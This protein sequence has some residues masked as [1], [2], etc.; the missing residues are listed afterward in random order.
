MTAAAIE[1]VRAC[2]FWTGLEY[3]NLVPA[4]EED[5]RQFVFGVRSDEELPWIAPELQRRLEGQWNR[6][7]VQVAYCGLFLKPAFAVSLH[8]ALGQPPGVASSLKIKGAAACCLIP[9]DDTG[10][11]CGELFFSSL[12]WFMSKLREHVSAGRSP[13]T[14]SVSGFADDE[15][16]L[17]SAVRALLVQRQLVPPEAT[18]E[19][20]A[21][22]SD[23]GSTSTASPLPAGRPRL[24]GSSSLPVATPT[25]PPGKDKQAS[26]GGAKAARQRISGPADMRPIKLGD[27]TAIL[28][29]MAKQWG[30]APPRIEAGV[31]AIRIKVVSVTEGTKTVELDAMNSL[32]AKDVIRVQQVL[33]GGGQLGDAAKAYLRLAP[34]LKR[35]DLRGEGLSHFVSMLSPAHLPVGAWPDFPLVSAQQFAVN[36]AC[37]HLAGGGLY[38]VNGPPGTGKSTLLRDVIADRLVERAH[39]MAAFDDPETAFI[40]SR[41]IEGR[42]FPYWTLDTRLHGI[43]TVVASSNN[44]AV[45][46]VI[47]DLPKLSDSM[48]KSGASYFRPVAES[49]ATPNHDSKPPRHRNVG[50]AWGLVAALLGNTKNRGAFISRFWFQKQL[51]ANVAPNPDQLWSLPG[52]MKSADFVVLPWKDAKQAFLKAMENSQGRAQSLQCCLELHREIRQQR[53]RLT[54]ATTQLEKATALC[55]QLTKEHSG[56][57]AA[58]TTAT[59][60]HAACIKNLTLAQACG[61]AEAAMRAAS[62]TAAALPSVEDASE[63]LRTADSDAAAAAQH[64]TLLQST[65]PGFFARLLDW[66]AMDTWRIRLDAAIDKSAAAQESIKQARQ[67]L[68]QSKEAVEALAVADR[69]L[70]AARYEQR[71]HA[72]L[73][74]RLGL[75]AGVSS[76]ALQD[77][78]KAVESANQAAAACRQ[79]LGEARRHAGALER[80]ISTLRTAIA[81]N[82]AEWS[83]LKAVTDELGESFFESCHLA[84]IPDEQLQLLVPYADP[85]LRELRVEVF[86]AAMALNESFVAASWRRLQPS[87]S[88]FVDYVSNKIPA[89]YTKDAGIHLWNAFFLTVP[90]VS[91]TFASI[92]SLFAGLESEQ[93]GLLLIDEA[94]QS[95]PQNALGAIWRS[96]RVIA[97]GDPLQLEPVVP[98]PKEI[99]AIWRKWTGANECWV[100][101]SCSAQTLADYATPYGTTLEPS[102]SAK[103]W[104]GSPLRVHRRCLNPM[105]SVA[106]KIAYGNLMVHGV[107]DETDG[108]EWVGPSRWYDAKSSGHSHWDE[109]QGQCAIRLVKLLL[110]TPRLN[111]SLRNTKGDWHVNVITP[112]SEVSSRFKELLREQFRDEL[113]IEAMAGTVHTF[114]GK[115]A[116]VVIL[117]LGGDPKNIGAI[118]GFAG[119]ETAPNLLNVALTRAKMRIYVV[120]DK[121]FWTDN[122]G[123]FTQLAESLGAA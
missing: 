24:G 37:Q 91:S 119:N 100:P 36:M 27:V 5:E 46:N 17:L 67:R 12:P 52:L 105:F 113:G 84:A 109:E 29:L 73:L 118:S 99:V 70:E 86:R 68:A 25:T 103:V 16:K 10:R 80:Q 32:V 74:K 110:D 48:E 62:T 33:A 78:V 22:T 47:K 104:V 111:R 39:V 85:K 64:C 94:G 21:A 114:Q 79:R 2:A 121:T 101:P 120:G 53:P 81:A 63:A 122:S 41:K 69:A 19:D 72:D 7:K 108:D 6:Y 116:D 44:G 58:A 61:K 90:V 82:E 65:K 56:L 59:Q 102:E 60:R 97:V 71:A 18:P 115:E 34:P 83:R 38:G 112:F 117:L 93:I 23:S 66:K 15:E 77:L 54:H 42:K 9:L 20:A 96:K 107:T 40:E 31:D 1:A 87:L 35:L 88:T 45:E 106:N 123:T 95:T 92:G 89:E 98:M 13:E 49:V 8:A 4:P 26:A 57:A 43:G 14:L 3:M 55:Q 30:W 50:S 76:G 75:P 11:I 28:E 51:D